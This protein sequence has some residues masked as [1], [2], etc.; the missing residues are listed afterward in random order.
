MTTDEAHE[1]YR[2]TIDCIERARRNARRLLAGNGPLLSGPTR[3]E[4]AHHFNAL[5]GLLEEGAER[6]IEAR[7]A[8]P[9]ED[10]WQPV[11]SQG[12]GL[13]ECG[14]FL[15]NFILDTPEGVG[16]VLV[17]LGIAACLCLRCLCK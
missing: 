11:Q 7:A 17:A 14:R 12:I 10:D 8:F 16:V 9:T 15:L 6:Q 4:V 13:G 5:M 1:L 3:L 2:E